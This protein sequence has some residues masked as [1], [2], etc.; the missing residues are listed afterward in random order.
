MLP[1][2]FGG[3]GLIWIKG[4]QI[5]M[6]GNFTLSDLHLRRVGVSCSGECGGQLL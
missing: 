4:L 2:V 1:G 5:N 3:E 6:G